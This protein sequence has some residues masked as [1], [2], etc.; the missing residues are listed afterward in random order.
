MLTRLTRG[1]QG[2]GK[3]APRSAFT[4]HLGTG[5]GTRDRLRGLSSNPA[6]PHPSHERA[7]GRVNQPVSGGF[8]F[9]HCKLFETMTDVS[10]LLNESTGPWTDVNGYKAPKHRAVMREG[11]RGPREVVQTWRR[12]RSCLALPPLPTQEPGSLGC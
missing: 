1:T 4:P 12:S 7:F 8:V 2:R 3:L 11:V 9:F 5:Q 6:L 10:W